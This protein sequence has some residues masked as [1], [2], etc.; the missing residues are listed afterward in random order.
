MVNP[1]MF[2]VLEVV[3]KEN[4]WQQLFSSTVSERKFIVALG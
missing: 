3:K 1:I 2:Q 4:V